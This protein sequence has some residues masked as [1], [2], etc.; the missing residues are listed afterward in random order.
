LPPPRIL[1][2]LP[3]PHVCRRRRRPSRPPPHQG[4]SLCLLS[5]HEW[6]GDALLSEEQPG[7]VPH[8]SPPPLDA[9]L[10]TTAVVVPSPVLCRLTDDRLHQAAPPRPLPPPPS[11]LGGR[12]GGSA[13]NSWCCPPL[14]CRSRL[15]LLHGS[16]IGRLKE[17][18]PMVQSDPLL[19]AA[20]TLPAVLVVQHKQ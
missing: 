18:L 2:T 1:Q 12:G 5:I 20:A 8:A 3:L 10:P 6:Q 14:A 13:S 16:Y 9:L 11:L 17:A 19:P 4:S 7:M 15:D